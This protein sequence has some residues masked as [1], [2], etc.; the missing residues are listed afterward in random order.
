MC[1]RCRLQAPDERQR[2]EILTAVLADTPVA[3]DVDLTSIA[4]QTAALV[5]QDI[6]SLVARAK[7]AAV[8]R[9]QIVK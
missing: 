6:V 8:Q 7:R 5:A 3:A 9:L 4:V 1:V 2:L